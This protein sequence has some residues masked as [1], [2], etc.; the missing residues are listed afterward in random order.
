MQTEY[1]PYFDQGVELEAFAARQDLKK[2]PLVFLCHPWAGKNEFICEKAKR[3]AELGFIGFANDMY[4]K[5]VVGK[6]SAENAALK[7][8]FLDDRHLLQRRLLKGFET[9]LS[10]DSIDPH[11]I[12]ALGYGFGGLCALDL[13]R[14]REDLL[15]AVAIHGHFEP[16]PYPHP[17]I[18]AK[19]LLLHGANDP[20]VPIHELF[21]FGKEQKTDWQA[22]IFGNTF[23]AF[24]NPLANDQAGGILY[25]AES[26]ERSWNEIERFL[27]EIFNENRNF[28][29]R[30]Q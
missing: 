6:S 21:T 29:R 5:G 2:R 30:N 18:R 22:H 23:H 15:G 25:N 10:L 16:A 3:I 28:S 20:V 7:K 26:A 13:A 14:N 8:P 12:V 24:P 1:I 19:I 17:E 9:A 27:E 11:R 4:G